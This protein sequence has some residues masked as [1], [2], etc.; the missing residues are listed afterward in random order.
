MLK[1][2]NFLKILKYKQYG[3]ANR[4]KLFKIR[5]EVF[6]NKFIYGYIIM[7][8]ILRHYLFDKSLKSR[9]IW[10]CEPDNYVRNLNKFKFV[11]N[12]LKL[13]YLL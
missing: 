6:K 3:T 9:I 11:Y 5:Q 12:F 4:I 8:I 2:M 10:Y 13:Q 7:K 1:Y